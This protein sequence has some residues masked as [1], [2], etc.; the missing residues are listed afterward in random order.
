MFLIDPIGKKIGGIGTL[1]RNFIEY[2]RD[3]FQMEFVGV[4][5][6][7][8]ERPVGYNVSG[9]QNIPFFSISCFYVSKFLGMFLIEDKETKKRSGSIAL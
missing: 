5:W 7:K 6:N 9:R 8:K 2:A 1:L 3:E 4:S